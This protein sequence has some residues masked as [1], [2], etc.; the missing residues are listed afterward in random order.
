MIISYSPL[1][2]VTKTFFSLLRLIPGNVDQSQNMFNYVENCSVEFQQ[3]H[4]H[5]CF[6]S[7]QESHRYV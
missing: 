4:L 7:D 3:V 5:V 6:L 2:H 1:A